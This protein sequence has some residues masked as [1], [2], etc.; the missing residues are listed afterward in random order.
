MGCVL[1]P[2]CWHLTPHLRLV[3]AQSARCLHQPRV[4]HGAK[5]TCCALHHLQHSQVACMMSTTQ[6]ACVMSSVCRR[7]VRCELE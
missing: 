3:C 2:T 1:C 6:A 4:K 7:C 5:H